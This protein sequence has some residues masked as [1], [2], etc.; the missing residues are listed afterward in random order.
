MDP[1]AAG[2]ERLHEDLAAQGAFLESRVPAYARLLEQIGQDLAGPLGA[3]LAKA[4]SARSFGAWYERPLLLMAG[5]RDDALREGPTHPLWHAVVLGEA[6]SVNAHAV[7]AAMGAERQHVWHCLRNRYVQTN[8]LSRAVAWLWPARLM[9]EADA[10]TPVALF[11]IGASAGLNLVADALGPM[12]EQADGRPLAVGPLPPIASR[13][14]VDLR[15]LDPRDPSEARWLRACI[16]PGQT[17]RE[18]RL[19]AAIEAFREQ[20]GSEHGPVLVQARASEVPALLP[21]CG[22]NRPRVLAYQ[23][24][25]RDYLSAEEREAYERG[26]R[27]WLAAGPPGSAL[28]VELEVT[29]E[30]KA[31]G[32]PTALTAHVRADRGQ[33]RSVVLAHCE[34]HPRVLHVQPGAEE[35]LRTALSPR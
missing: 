35:T 17:D 16:W 32:R 13:T 25:M 11:D 20:A 1:P 27:Q 12:W 18:E 34:P 14:G 23:T 2:T 31:G 24:I 3:R 28:W 8:E 26:M 21:Q 6:A 10:T 15:P 9:G 4:W 29:G 19:A 7:Q 5:L 22:P 30:A 33:V